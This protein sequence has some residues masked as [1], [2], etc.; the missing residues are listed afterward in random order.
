MGGY[1]QYF[2]PRVLCYLHLDWS[3]SLFPSC[4]VFKFI[5]YPSWFSSPPFLPFP[6]PPSPAIFT[7]YINLGRGLVDFLGF[8]IFLSLVRSM[9]VCVCVVC[10]SVG[11]HMHSMRVDV[12]EVPKKG[13]PVSVVRCGCESLNVGARAHFV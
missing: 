11:M 13:H 3:E 4:F 7:I 2:I 6:L 8:R 5:V 1:S 10:E 12:P 9:C